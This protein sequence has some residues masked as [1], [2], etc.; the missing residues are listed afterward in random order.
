MNE[1]GINQNLE[2]DMGGLADEVQRLRADFVKLTDILKSTAEHAGEEAAHK[3]REAGER[4]WTETKNRADALLQHIESRP[5]S[6]AAVAL[7][8]GF[9]LGLIFGGRRS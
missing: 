4:A 6:S 9:F 7:G 5:V 8:F 1:N 3:A 2:S